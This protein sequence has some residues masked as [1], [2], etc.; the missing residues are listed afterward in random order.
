MVKPISRRETAVEVR[1]FI[2]ILFIPNRS[3]RI[4]CNTH[5]WNL[6][7]QRG[8][9]PGG[10]VWI[11][12]FCGFRGWVWGRLRSKVSKSPNAFNT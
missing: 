3:S 10:G 2:A 12:P 7:G 9:Y 5:R 4:V 11:W 1:S 6:L 8:E